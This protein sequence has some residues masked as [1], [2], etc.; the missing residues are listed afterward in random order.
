MQVSPAWNEENSLKKCSSNRENF[1]FLYLEVYALYKWI[2]L[3]GRE[4]AENL[5]LH[6]RKFS[7]PIYR[8]L[9]LIQMCNPWNEENLLRNYSSI[10]E[11]FHT[12]CLENYA[13]CKWVLLGKKRIRLKSAV[14]IAII[15]PAYIWK[16]YKW[17]PLGTKRI[18]LKIA[19]P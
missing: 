12:L 3:E 2:R 14:P 17:V 13:S 15:S 18:R 4:F 6:S 9:C 8:A 7:L 19:A 10:S 5:Q 1:P 16:F 11:N